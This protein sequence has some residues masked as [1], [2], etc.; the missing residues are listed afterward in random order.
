M[1][2]S[3]FALKPAL[4]KVFQD[5]N[6]TLERRQAEFERDLPSAVRLLGTG[7]SGAGSGPHPA[8]WA[9]MTAVTRAILNLSETITLD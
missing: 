2:G 3:D 5:F 8:N 6:K 7:T 4:D 9:A 1:R